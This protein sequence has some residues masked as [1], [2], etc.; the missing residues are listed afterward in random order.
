MRIAHRFRPEKSTSY[1]DAQ[2]HWP[3]LR[4]ALAWPWP[5]GREV[6]F[7]VAVMTMRII[8]AGSWAH[9]VNSRANW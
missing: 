2:R 6:H 8:M 4:T 7:E 5:P 1:P 3:S 9:S